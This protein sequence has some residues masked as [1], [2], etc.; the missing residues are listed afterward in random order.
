MKDNRVL[1]LLIVLI[2]LGGSVAATISFTNFIKYLSFDN[3]YK[4]QI[5]SLSTLVQINNQKFKTLDSTTYL[6][7]EKINQLQTKLSDLSYRTTK[8]QK[9]YEEQL[10]RLNR[11]TDSQLVIKFT[12]IFDYD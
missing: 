11:L 5:D 8:N 3:S 7:Q 9:R 1:K 10:D 4:K 6:Q 2:L 12:D